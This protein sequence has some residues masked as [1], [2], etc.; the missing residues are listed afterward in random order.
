MRCGA[1]RPAKRRAA[2]GANPVTAGNAAAPEPSAR[3]ATSISFAPM[4]PAAGSMDISMCV[5]SREFVR[6]RTSLAGRPGSL[7]T[8]PILVARAGFPRRLF[9]GAAVA[10]REFTHDRQ[11]P[12]EEF[13]P[14]GAPGRWRKMVCLLG[15]WHRR[16]HRHGS[17]ALSA[18][19]AGHPGMLR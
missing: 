7:A 12:N 1:R 8:Q 5:C 2:A 15:F 14:R 11:P 10:E 6:G 18:L 3:L 16:W 19:S 4:A 9:P 17:S 13:T